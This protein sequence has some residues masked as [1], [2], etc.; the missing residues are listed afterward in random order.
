MAGVD[1]TSADLRGADFRQANLRTAVL[2][3]VCFDAT[4]IWGSNRPPTS[5]SC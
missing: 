1:S 5:S 2:T 4:T 3:D